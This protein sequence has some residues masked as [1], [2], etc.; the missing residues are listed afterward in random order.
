MPEVRILPEVNSTNSFL[1]K[2]VKANSVPNHFVVRTHNQT[3]GKGRGNS[4]WFFD[5]K[6]SLAFSYLYKPDY[7]AAADVFYLN[8]AVTT[9]LRDHFQTLAK[10]TKIKWPND[11]YLGD[12]KVCGILIQN[13]WV[14]KQLKESVIGVGVNVKQTNFPAHLSRATS[15]EAASGSRCDL[16]TVF[17]S[18]LKACKKQLELIDSK[19]LGIL[20]DQYIKNLY[21]KDRMHTFR[22]PNGDRLSGKITGVSHSGEL[23]IKTEGRVLRFKSK[24]IS[25]F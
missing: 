3:D 23:Q 25:F 9:A 5:P 22:L 17:E 11:I 4:A 18:L 15:L 7:L 2:L 12:R 24:E 10:N 13:R 20:A 1:M 19:Q 8:M 6:S 14:G 21:L 16:N